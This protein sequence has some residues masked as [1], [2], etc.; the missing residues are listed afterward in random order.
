MA[1]SSHGQA[2]VPYIAGRVHV[3]YNN[4]CPQAQRKKDIHHPTSTVF[5][6]ILP[7]SHTKLVT[8][9]G[10]GYYVKTTGRWGLHVT[11]TVQRSIGA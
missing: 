10:E 11:Y 7:P 2:T 1:R 8:S 6:S 3:V 9:Y 4:A 5:A